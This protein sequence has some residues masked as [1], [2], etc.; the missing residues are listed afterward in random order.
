M[1]GLKRSRA[2]LLVCG[3]VLALPPLPWLTTSDGSETS[4]PQTLGDE[5]GQNDF[6]FEIG[7][8]VTQLSLLQDPLTGS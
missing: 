5:D 4:L 7:T 1:N 3:L 2:Y 8:W 6:D